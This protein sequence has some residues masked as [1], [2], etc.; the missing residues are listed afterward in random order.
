MAQIVDVRPLVLTSSEYLHELHKW[1]QYIKASQQHPEARPPRPDLPLEWTVKTPTATY[2]VSTDFLESLNHPADLQRALDHL[3]ILR[4]AATASLAASTRGSARKT[5]DSILNRWEFHG[6][7]T[8][9]VKESLRDR[10]DQM[11]IHFF[12][13]LFGKA[14][15]N[16]SAIRTFVTLLT[17]GL[18]LSGAAIIFFWIF[19]ALRAFSSPPLALEGQPPEYISSKSAESWLAEARHAAADGQYRLAIALAYWAAIAGLERAGAWRPD[20]ARTPREYLRHSAN[21]TFLPVLRSLT[22]VFERT[23]YANQPATA[24]EFE[25]CLS[26]V[27]ELGWQ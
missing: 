24:V 16:A 3:H 25:D 15:E 4:E 26:R 21:A 10:I 12:Q 9:G 8:P 14:V 20:R 17:W 7:Q 27:K 18:L 23:W 22:T 5:A 2:H 1:Q 13:R 19:R 11:L 6:V